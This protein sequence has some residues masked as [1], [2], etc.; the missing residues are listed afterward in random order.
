MSKGK[1][2]ISPKTPMLS[3]IDPGKRKSERKIFEDK[4]ETASSQPCK[5]KRLTEVLKAPIPSPPKTDSCN[6]FHNRT[7]DRTKERENCTVQD[8]G[9]LGILKDRE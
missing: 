6:S 8:L 5:R 4:E 3:Y 7:H 9:N 1:E 2:R